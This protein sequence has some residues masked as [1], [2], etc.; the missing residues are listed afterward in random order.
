[1]NLY[2]LLALRFYVVETEYTVMKNV[3]HNVKS[4]KKNIQM[5]ANGKYKF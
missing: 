4:V 2:T 1:M 5:K 3:V